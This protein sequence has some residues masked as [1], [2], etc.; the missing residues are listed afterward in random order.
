MSV[1]S[2]LQ[3]SFEN[4][5]G[6]SEEPWRVLRRTLEGSLKNLGRFRNRHSKVIFLIICI[7]K[8]KSAMF[9]REDSNVLLRRLERSPE[10]TRTFSREDSNVLSR[11][12]QYSLE[13]TP[14]FSKHL[15]NVLFLTKKEHHSMLPFLSHY[16]LPFTSVT[17]FPSSIHITRE[18][19]EASCCEWVT[20]I[21]VVPSSWS[22]FSSC[23]TSCPFFESRLPVGS[24]ANISLGFDTKARAIATR[25][26]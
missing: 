19:Y 8:I 20:I 5:G 3:C 13:K 26:C 9:S 14:M 10:K 2:T 24:S 22:S 17:I 12:L 23:I 11:R 6:F 4:L 1:F 15:S 18:A 25:C 21:M 7:Q 16:N